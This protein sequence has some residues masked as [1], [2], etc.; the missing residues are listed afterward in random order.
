MGA[1][2]MPF[3]TLLSRAQKLL[4]VTLIFTANQLAQAEKAV[5]ID[6]KSPLFIDFS[7]SQWNKN[8]DA[9]DAAVLLIRNGQSSKSVIATLTEDGRNSN[10]FTGQFFITW[11]Q[12]GPFQADIYSPPQ[13]AAQKGDVSSIEKMIKEGL[14]PRKPYF[15]RKEGGVQK[16]SVYNSAAQALE[17]YTQYRQTLQGV[18]QPTTKP[19]VDRAAIEAARNAEIA[20]EQAR[21]A[22]LAQQQEL[23]RHQQ[24]EEA[25]RKQEELKRQQEALAAGERQKRIERAAVEA[26]EALKL[27]Q[28]QKYVE[29]EAKF[30]TSIEL[31]PAQTSYNFQY[32]ATLY[33]NQKYSEAL[34]AFRLANDASINPREKS[35]YQGLCHMKLKEYA[36]ALEQFAIVTSVSDET[37]TPSASFFS[38]IIWFSQENYK[39]AKAAFER[40]LDTS[41]D[42]QLDEQADTYIEQIANIE[43]FQAKLANR[44][45][46]S[47]STGLMYD[48][49]IPLA[50]NSAS[51]SA[52]NK[53]GFRGLINVGL[54]YRIIYT[55]THE[56]HGDVSYSDMYSM[57]PS[58]KANA[59]LQ[60]ADPMVIAAKLP[61]KW[62]GK[63]FQK[64]YLV[65]ITPG[66]EALRLNVDG[67]GAREYSMGSSILATEQTFIVR[68]DYFTIV[69]L[70]WRG[71][72]S[73]I[74]S[75][76]T[77]DAT[78]VTIGNNNLLFLDAKKTQAALL[79]WSYLIN[80]TSLP[81][82]AFNKIE[83][84]GGYLTPIFQ[85]SNWT[86]MLSLSQSNFSK[87]ATNRKDNN[88][89]FSSSIGSSLTE[90]LQGTLGLGYETNTSSVA[91]STYNKYT[92]TA[93]VNWAL[94]F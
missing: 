41:K 76:G 64:P 68:D 73:K 52:T 55:E 31:D 28:D 37:L 90:K 79:N 54:E 40:T 87:S 62:K 81:E 49:N 58:F 84:A 42:P 48:T 11:D 13:K 7:F 92:L 19:I 45:T 82:N 61:Y 77:A 5:Q 89:N 16:L 2:A 29:A 83:L 47:A 15:L 51:S 39:P 18:N 80:T 24:A 53:A 50:S 32:G 59:T 27:F 44:F 78:K 93:T 43:Q 67:V 3:F 25:Q 14:L 34:V 6:P 23:L 20:A 94:D 85:K 36:S 88:V 56:L 65:S 66:V 69:K 12:E 17:A 26:K 1:I 72:D 21:L 9:P 57:D 74:A 30:R 4:L 35:F 75:S 91:I 22:K 70:D 46:A 8:P 10:R 71:E 63:L 38:G 86:N 33:K 60:M